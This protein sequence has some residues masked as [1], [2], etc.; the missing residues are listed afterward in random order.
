M[1]KLGSIV[2]L[3][4]V[5]LLGCARTMQASATQPNPLAAPGET[6]PQS[7]RLHIYVGMNDMDQSQKVIMRN[8]AYFVV[9][10][11]DRLRFHVTLE[12]AW[13]ELATV[14][15]WKAWL[16]DDRGTRYDPV[17]QVTYHNRHLT[18]IWDHEQRSAVRNAYGDVVQ[19]E[20]DGYKHRVMQSSVDRFRGQGDY[21]FYSRDIFRRDLKRVALVMKHGGVEYRYVWNFNENGEVDVLDYG[22]V[23]LGP[24]S[25]VR[26]GP[27]TGGW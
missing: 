15:E 3:L 19:V 22:H 7:E 11:R 20:N 23:Q 27:I 9:V 5:C 16:E 26:P 2:L 8:S 10:S 4:C 12:H 18:R 24:G 17:S 14:E 13:E 21:V 6:L 25:D 1:Q